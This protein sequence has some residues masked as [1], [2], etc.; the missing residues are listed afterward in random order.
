[1]GF[2]VSTAP[3]IARSVESSPGAAAPFFPLST[4]SAST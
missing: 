4:V 2:D 1:M 3:K